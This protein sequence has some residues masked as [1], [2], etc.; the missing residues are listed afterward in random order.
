MDQQSAIEEIALIRRIIEESR[1]FTF[2]IGK[3][4]IVWGILIS[5][6]IF[7]SFG[8][9]V[10][11][12][13]GMNL[14]I[15]VVMIGAG[16]VF[17]IITGIC[18]RSIPENIGV[19]IISTVWTSCGIAMTILGFA[20]ITSG[21]IEDWAIA[22]VIATLMGTGFA[23]TA[24]VQKS[25]WVKYVA[26]AWWLG[27]LLMFFVKSYEALP[28]FGVMMILFMVVP[29]IVFHTQWKNNQTTAKVK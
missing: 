29:G 19:R 6:A 15:W 8:A 13:P 26:V 1:E 18:K 25:R 9:I 20:G 22:P 5:V 16:W 4:I 24:F 21:A 2:N 12:Y 23:G 14:W 7:A 17:S 10:A 11:G 28:I 27:A 3:N